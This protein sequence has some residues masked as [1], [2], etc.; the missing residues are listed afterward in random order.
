MEHDADPCACD[1]QCRHGQRCLAGHAMYPDR[2]WYVC[3]TCDP[4]NATVYVLADRTYLAVMACC[5]R[6]VGPN[7][8]SLSLA[9][10]GRE[11]RRACGEGVGAPRT[12]TRPVPAAWLD[13]IIELVEIY[14]CNSARQGEECDGHHLGRST[15]DRLYRMGRCEV[16]LRVRERIGG[17]RAGASRQPFR[18]RLST[19]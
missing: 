3:E 4:H 14:M 15:P 6:A 11:H 1:A 2:H 5:G 9:Q 17:L 16:A 18:A 7:A 19:D 10:A 8:R 12:G 13:E